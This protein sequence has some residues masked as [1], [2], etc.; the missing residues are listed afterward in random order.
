[1]VRPEKYNVDDFNTPEAFE[2]LHERGYQ[3]VATCPHRDDYTHETLPL[4]KP[5]A[6]VFGTEKTGLTDYAIEHADMYVRLPMVGFTES[7]NISVSAALLMFTL[8]QRLH[9]SVDVEWHLTEDE[10]TNYVWTGLAKHSQK[11]ACM[12]VNSRNYILNILY[13]Y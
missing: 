12:N 10:K 13:D 8:T 4:D 7:F 9:K 1:M 5:V 6:L 11:Q 3:I 2:H